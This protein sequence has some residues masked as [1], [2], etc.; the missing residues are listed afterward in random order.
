MDESLYGFLNL[1]N[2]YQ[3]LIQDSFLN[4]KSNLSHRKKIAEIY[5]ENLPERIMFDKINSQIDN[6]SNLRF[7]IL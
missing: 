7:P 3:K 4:L 5:K 6:S 1:P 2:F